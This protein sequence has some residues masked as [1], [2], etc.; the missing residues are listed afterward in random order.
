MAFQGIR[1][2]QKDQQLS[3]TFKLDG[4]NEPVTATARVVW[5]TDSR[6]AG[7]LQFVDLPEASR[8][9]IRDWIEL[10]K[11]AESPQHS[12][13]MKITPFKAMMT[14]ILASEPTPSAEPAKAKSNPETDSSVSKSVL[15]PPAAPTPA[16]ISSTPAPAK[17]TP[18]ASVEPVIAAP[19]VVPAQPAQANITPAIPKA[20]VQAKQS[21]SLQAAPAVVNLQ[22]PSRT[23]SQAVSRKNKSGRFFYLAIGLAAVVAMAVACVVLLWPYRERLMNLLNRDHSSRV[24]STFRAE[25]P[26]PAEQNQGFTPP[27]DLPMT[28]PSQWSPVA[29]PLA[30]PAAPPAAEANKMNPRGRQPKSPAQTA[31]ASKSGRNSTAPG[32]SSASSRVTTPAITPAKASPPAAAA[33]PISAA[34]EISKGLPISAATKPAVP[35]ARAAESSVTVTGSVEIISDPYPS[36]RMPTASQRPTSRLGASLQIGRLVS[37]GDPVYPPDALRQNITGTVKMHIVINESGAVESAVLVSG[38]AALADAAM[39]A[40]KGWRYE[41]TIIGGAPVEV[42]EEV[43]LVFRIA[44]SSVPAK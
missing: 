6:K 44:N 9:L 5:L 26:V 10:Q 37:K 2:L 18:Q 7:A 16:P 19:A 22:P 21:Q 32:V 41:P 31:S 28:D 15:L 24:A 4:I 1:P 8:Q 43:T 14:P 12:A 27:S 25:S 23:T 30:A 20:E 11:K 35:E 36:I 33:P 40:V 17:V 29:N 39:R 38:P 34:S 3:I 13:E 42:E